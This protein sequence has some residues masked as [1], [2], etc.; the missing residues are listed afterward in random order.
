LGHSAV[1]RDLG[2]KLAVALLAGGSIWVTVWLLPLTSSQH[3]SDRRVIIRL[4]RLP[5]AEMVQI[6]RV[7][8]LLFD[9]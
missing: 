2:I 4:G 7:I 6:E 9:L 8:R 3:L 5:T 1:P